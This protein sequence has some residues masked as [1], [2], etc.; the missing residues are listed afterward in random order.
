M[1]QPQPLD[2]KPLR[3]RPVDRDMLRRIMQRTGDG[4]RASMRDIAE[5]A[6]VA[7]SLIAE[8]LSG[9]QDTVS[10]DVAEA[11]SARVG[12]DLLVLWLPVQRTTIARSSRTPAGSAVAR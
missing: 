11:W 10:P 8:V 4:S 6:G 12:C 1:P 9:E 2:D 7:S 3:Y 5:V